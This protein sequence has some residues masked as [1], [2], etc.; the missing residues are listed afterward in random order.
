MM[1]QRLLILLYCMFLVGCNEKIPLEKVSLILLMA[2]DRTSNEE[3]KIGV[4]IPLFQNNKHKHTLELET[5]AL[6]LYT[7]FSKISTQVKGYLTSSKAQVILI[8]KKFAQKDNW[9]QS[10][11]STYRDPY[12]TLNTKVVL[13]D[14]FA[15][16]ILKIKQDNI[17]YLS[18]YINDTIESSIQNN[19]SISSTVQQLMKEKNEEGMTQAIPIIKR[20]KN[21]IDTVGIAFF[22]HNGKYIYQI[23]KKDVQLYNLINKPKHT[24][25][26]ILHLP[27]STQHSQPKS[28]ISVLVQDAKRKIRVN[29]HKG[30]FV[31]NIDLNLNLSL[32]EKSA[33]QATDYAQ[34]ILP[35]KKL[36]TEIKQE[37]DRTLHKLLNNIQKQK[38]DPL[39][40]S[41]YAR[42]FQYK[43][44]KILK[45]EWPNIFS[46]A[47]IQINTHVTVKR[48]G[49][50][51]N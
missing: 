40:L 11:D 17:S 44:W 45:K 1:Q 19:Q 14:G 2:V 49:T 6:T 25:R 30:S 29:F 20:I 15:T 7:G 28:N 12:S 42:A 48:T 34:N 22:N 47:K 23:S 9:I 50:I 18:S 5:K 35:V 10:L 31:F 43:E 13:V 27:I 33:P 21:N 46:K 38:I 24:G 39:G 8:G 51:R 41:L 16:D 26:M 32:I 36:E 3:I 4:S 37:I